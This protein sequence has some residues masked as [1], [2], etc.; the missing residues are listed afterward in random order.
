MTGKGRRTQTTELEEWLEESGRVNTKILARL[1]GC[2]IQS[3]Q[4]YNQDGV[5]PR[6]PDGKFVLEKCIPLFIAWCRKG[7]PER[8]RSQAN[9]N[10]EK[11]RLTRAQ[12]DRAELD[13]AE[14]SGEVI[15]AA[16][17]VLAWEQM[18]TNCKNKVLS[19]PSK[20]APMFSAE[21][22]TAVI[23]DDLENYLRDA[24]QELSDGESLGAIHP[25][26]AETAA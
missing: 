8:E 2:T 4:K 25:P 9:F 15:D 20:A 26:G 1:L 21:T 22:D 5:F 7:G 3:V 12:A 18:L 10:E 6:E 19:I 17:A 16:E 23:Q 14:K 13:L 11:A 24:L